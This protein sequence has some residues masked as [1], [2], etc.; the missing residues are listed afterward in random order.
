MSD[1]VSG[2]GTSLKD[3]R[4]K[5]WKFT[6]FNPHP[7]QQKIVKL[8]DEVR[9]VVV[10]AGRR[11]GKS[12]LACALAESYLLQTNKSVAIISATYRDCKRLASIIDDD[13]CIKG[14]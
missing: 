8:H 1:I 5:W 14:C 9:F 4:S 6:G 3:F 13:I 7:G 2:E 11:F 12:R 10:C